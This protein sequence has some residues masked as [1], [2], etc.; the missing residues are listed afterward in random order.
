MIKEEDGRVDSVRGCSPGDCNFC[1]L[2]DT[3]LSDSG[4]VAFGD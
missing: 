2:G 4:S 3:A 1:P